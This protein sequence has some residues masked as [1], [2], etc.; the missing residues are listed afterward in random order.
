MAIT[1]KFPVA[2][3]L[4]VLVALEGHDHK[5]TSDIIASSTGI[6]PVIIRN[7]MSDL[8]KA[9]IIDV[10]R[11]SGGISISRDSS[12]ISLLDIF[13][14]VDGFGKT[15][16]LFSIHEKPN[17]DCFVGKNVT[18]VLNCTFSSIEQKV[19]D[20]LSVISL[21]DIIEQFKN[22]NE[23]LE[24]WFSPSYFIFENVIFDITSIG[25]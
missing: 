2:I 16:H 19:F 7:C 20:E 14:A 10:K 15:K 21:N 1:T 5:I 11:G 23:N 13:K 3:H 22:R 8:R 4:L 25:W 9:Q 18:Q 24:K 17:S 6:N 12:S